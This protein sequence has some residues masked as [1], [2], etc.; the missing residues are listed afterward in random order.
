M[1][2]RRVLGSI[3]ELVSQAKF[4]LIERELSPFD[5]SFLLNETPMSYLIYGNSKE[6]FKSLKIERE[7]DSNNSIGSNEK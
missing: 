4:Y 1:G 7:G 5:V 6:A 2:D 3:N